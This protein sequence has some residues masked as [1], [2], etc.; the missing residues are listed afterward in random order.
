MA[1]LNES[2]LSK[3]PKRATLA[4]SLY[5]KS[6]DGEKMDVYRRVMLLTNLNNTQ[7]FLNESLGFCIASIVYL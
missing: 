1:N 3:F 2:V 5:K 7:K 6:H 4:E